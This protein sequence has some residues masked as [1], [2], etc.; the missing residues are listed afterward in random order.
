MVYIIHNV[1]DN[2]MINSTEELEDIWSEFLT[3]KFSTT[4]LETTREAYPDLGNE[5]GVGQL[6]HEFQE[7]VFKLK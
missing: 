7:A 6:T 1:T 5:D 3:N 2:M 4:E